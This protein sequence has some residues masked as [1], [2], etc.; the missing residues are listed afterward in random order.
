MLL[1]WLLLVEAVK[2]W[3]CQWAVFH[4]LMRWKV[5]DGAS[6]KMASDLRA[7]TA[8]LTPLLSSTSQLPINWD[9][10]G[11]LRQLIQLGAHALTVNT[12]RERERYNVPSATA[13]RRRSTRTHISFCPLQRRLNSRWFLTSIKRCHKLTPRAK[14]QQH[15]AVTVSGHSG[16]WPHKPLLLPSASGRISLSL[17]SQAQLNVFGASLYWLALA[18][19]RSIRW[20]AAKPKLKGS[21]E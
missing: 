10:A 5:E 2:R 12:E 16:G 7:T 4:D 1:V 19:P 8:A 13:Q 17:F 11:Q 15:W 21:D 20:L 9:R 6:T 18:R 3:R 14:R